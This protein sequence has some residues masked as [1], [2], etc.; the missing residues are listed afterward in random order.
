[1]R[2]PALPASSSAIGLAAFRPAP[3]VS[4][5]QHTSN[6]GANRNHTSSLG[7]YSFIFNILAEPQ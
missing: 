5:G 1:L 4:A 7:E 3:L 6:P 2:L